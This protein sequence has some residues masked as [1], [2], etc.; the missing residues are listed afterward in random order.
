MEKMKPLLS[1]YDSSIVVT[2]IVNKL[3]HNLQEKW[4]YTAVKYM[5]DHDVA[6][7][8]FGIFV[9]CIRDQSR[10]KNNPSFQYG[11]SQVNKSA[12]F[13]KHPDKSGIH[14]RKTETTVKQKCPLHLTDHPLNKCRVFK[15]KPIE[16]RIK[17]LKEKIQV[18]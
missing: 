9:N 10:I 3:S 2:P 18:L 7:P 14:V 8:P 4:T 12:N 15:A 17:F 11:G 1:H 13:Q 5:N 6:Y 16:E